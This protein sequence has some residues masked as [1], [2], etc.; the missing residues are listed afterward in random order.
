MA[1]SSRKL[2]TII[3]EKDIA[4]DISK[5]D[6]KEYNREELLAIFTELEFNSFIKKMGLGGR[7]K[8]ERFSTDAVCFEELENIDD[9]NKSINELKDKSHLAMLPIISKSDRV[10]GCLEA[11]AIGT[12]DKYYYASA[13]KI[14]EKL[15]FQ[16]L[17]PV[18][19]DTKLT[20]I[21]HNI[22]ELYLWVLSFN[23]HINCNL[24][25]MM[26]AEYLIDAL[27][28]DYS[29]IN[30]AR[31]YLGIELEMPKAEK[32]KGK[33]VHI[34]VEDDKAPELICRALYTFKD[35]YKQQ[36][37]IIIKQSNSL[38]YDGIASSIVLANMVLGFRVD[39]D[40]LEASKE[41]DQRINSL[42][43]DNS[44]MAEIFNIIPKQLGVLFEKW[45]LLV[46][47]QDRAINR[48]RIIE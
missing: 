16:A 5:F 20:L 42:S 10:G 23:T 48:C 39:K 27:S 9:L 25:D 6:R 44:Y 36:K 2:G 11:V 29:I 19:N 7:W 13:D 32:G 46:K 40:Y 47:D 4:D 17:K 8:E 28:P 35:I 41:L 34:I 38:F 15:L 14:E 45:A 1:F 12:Q 43:T 22:K 37:A 21:T 33:Q 30:L 26:I 3:R 18:F 31:K 24:F